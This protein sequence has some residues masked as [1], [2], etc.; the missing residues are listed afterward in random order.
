MLQDADLRELCAALRKL[1]RLHLSACSA[2]SDDGFR[3]AHFQALLGILL[4]TPPELSGS[5]M[6]Y[7]SLTQADHFYLTT[8]YG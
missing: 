4:T 3:F 6:T 2:L 8:R 5:F 7:K 1:K